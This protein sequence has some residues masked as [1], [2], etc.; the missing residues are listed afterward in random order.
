MQKKWKDAVKEWFHIKTGGRSRVQKQKQVVE[1]DSE[2]E[3]ALLDP[4]ADFYTL[5]A[6]KKHF[7]DPVKN[8]ANVR[9]SPPL[10]ICIN[11]LTSDA[12]VLNRS[13]PVSSCRPGMGHS[14]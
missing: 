2:G 3:F 11:S 7:G 12:C 9:L 8:K 6:Y 14:V 1:E 10:G 4:E 5:K 13:S